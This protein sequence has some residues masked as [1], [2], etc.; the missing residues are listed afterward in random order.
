MAWFGG[1]KIKTITLAGSVGMAITAVGCALIPMQ[2]ALVAG[3]GAKTMQDNIMPSIAHLNTIKETM[4]AV[5]IASVKQLVPLSESERLANA[6]K[7]DGQITTIDKALA[8]YRPLIT[9]ATEQGMYD[10]VARI[11][12]GWKAQASQLQSLAKGDKATATVFYEKSLS[13]IGPQL[14]KAISAEMA[15]N[16][17]KGRDLTD[18]GAQAIAQAIWWGGALCLFALVQ[19][20]ALIVLMRKRVTVPLANLAEA[21]Q[22]MAQGQLDREVRHR[23][24]NDEVGNIAQALG[25]IKIGVAT[26]TRAAAEKDM[27][28]QAL[29]VSEL[30]DGLGRM[31]AQDL[32]VRIT[33][34]FPP[35]YEQLR[36]DF[37]K[38]ADAL[39]QA[40]GTVRVGARSLLA[41]IGE[42]NAAA[43]DLAHRNA[44]QAATLEETTA[45]LRQVTTGVKDIAGRT[46]DM[47]S[48]VTETH[49]EATRGSGV[50]SRAVD[51]MGAIEASAQEINQI[52]AVID[53]IAFQTNLL[54]LNAGVEAARAGD[55]GKGFAVVA[56][57]VR[58]LAQ[59]CADAAKDIKT[60][61]SSSVDQVS[62]GVGLVR[63]T[64]DL[65]STIMA[66]VG[67]INAVAA[68]I[69][70]QVDVQSRH[71]VQVNAS[72]G[73]IDRVTQQNAAMVEE[74]SAA[75]RDMA[76]EAQ[77]LADLVN[78]FRTREPA[79]RPQV[80]GQQNR[81]QTLAG[82]DQ[83]QARA[84][85]S[86]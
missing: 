84:A 20:A 13:P 69:A 53:G 73:E 59:R 70:A 6:Q 60:L 35:A 81:R 76:S 77:G 51:A 42:I 47:Q 37:N 24:L 16:Q 26:R 25:G 8:E 41:T 74:T 50:V 86:A 30:R 17:K 49:E 54:A 72:V 15:Y 19:A 36:V 63:E 33:A 64:G 83:G 12:T 7:L 14:Q 48:Q 4:I 18:K 52:I 2:S 43:A 44:E 65:L 85:L 23:D 78:R 27:A 67:D 11:W 46:S 29:I 75:T 45:A 21:M 5:R 32:E 34:D 31:A 62:G 22:D 1:L 38:A 55:A 56:N 40:I 79:S 66:R 57:E 68:E 10:E 28:E 61:I 9:D 82:R 39:A 71:I 3:A 80:G 58:A